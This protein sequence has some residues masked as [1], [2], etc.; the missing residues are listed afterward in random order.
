M[1]F[2]SVTLMLP[3]SATWPEACTIELEILPLLM[4]IGTVWPLPH[5]ELEEAI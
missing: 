4:P 2:T 1:P 5:S 3:A